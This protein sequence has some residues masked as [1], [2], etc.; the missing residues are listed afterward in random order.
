MPCDEKRPPAG[1]VYCV[2]LSL[3]LSRFTS[4]PIAATFP[5]F[6]FTMLR[7]SHSQVQGSVPPAPFPFPPHLQ[8]SLKQ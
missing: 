1:Y 8:P 4:L 6:H 5:S 7:D 2:G 3:S